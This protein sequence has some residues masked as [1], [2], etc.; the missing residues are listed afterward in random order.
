MLFVAQLIGNAGLLVSVLI[1]AR[2]LGP[3][4][5]GTTAFVLVTAQVVAVVAS[6][7]LPQASLVLVAEQSRRGTLLTNLIVFQ[8]A[9]ATATALVVC[10]TLLVAGEQRPKGVGTSEI[11]TLGAATVAN[12]LFHAGDQF[13]LGSGRLLQRGTVI[14]VWPWTYVAV[15][16][17]LVLL[18]GLDVPAV[19]GAWTVCHGVAALWLLGTA[20]RAAGLGRLDFELLMRALRFGG[21]LWPGN[22]AFF[23]N[24]RV[25]Q[26]L[27]GFITTQATLGIY[28]VAVNASEPLLYL[29]GAVASALLPL[30]TRSAPRER[31][32]R[33]LRAFRSLLI[34]SAATVL[35]AAALGPIVIP[36]VFGTA[37][38]AS[39]G[40]FLL[41]LPGT[42]GYVVSSVFSSSLLGASRPGLSSLAAIT[43]LVVGVGLD[44]ALIPAFG[45][46]GAAAAASG[47][48]VAGGFV[49]ILAYR[50][51]IREVV[52]RGQML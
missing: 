16:L 30:I 34:P 22:L 2:A 24:F 12:G 29:P 49:A 27:M 48:F 1:V 21:R 31:H 8:L 46:E 36:V 19:I 38:A 9:A 15:L 51:H 43:S 33:A 44:L 47:A 37:F 42:M 50:Q 20:A 26:I 23:L 25:D 4:G 32:E 45:A 40:P 11:L 18:I 3:D 52:S 7:G 5:R 39:V 6:F 13:L 17:S 28:A 14:A 10:A 41:L 35:A